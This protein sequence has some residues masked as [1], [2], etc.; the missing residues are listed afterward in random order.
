MQIDEEEFTNIQDRWKEV[1]THGYDFSEVS[2]FALEAVPALIQMVKM[3]QKGKEIT[4]SINASE[5]VKAVSDKIDA[6]LAEMKPAVDNDAEDLTSDVSKKCESCLRDWLGQP[7]KQVFGPGNDDYGRKR[8]A[9]GVT[10][11]RH[12]VWGL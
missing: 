8:H 1:V 4:V 10:P 6:V 3:L 9:G 11:L 12:S 5:A 7:D 2:D